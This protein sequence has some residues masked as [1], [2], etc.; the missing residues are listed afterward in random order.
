ML[1]SKFDLY[2]TEWLELVFANRNKEYGAY[3]MRAHYASTLTRAMAITF[4]AVAAMAT[5]VTI[6]SN[7]KTI[8]NGDRM[9]PVELPTLPT[10]PDKVVEIKKE[11]PPA[12]KI[13]TQPA[14][15]PAISTQN[16]NYKVV[17]D[18]KVKIDPKPVDPN[19][20]SGPVDIIV[21]GSDPTIQ[22]QGEGTETGKGVDPKSPGIDEGIHNTGELLDVMPEPVGGADAWGRFLQKNLRFPVAARE[23]GISGKVFL[24][25]IIEKDGHLTDITV[26][27]KAGSGFDEESLR[28]LKLAPAWKPGMQNGQKVRVRYTIP[29]NFQL[30]DE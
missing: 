9:V 14:K 28:V 10:N 30:A 29:I 22:N 6:I 27:R 18:D 24:S 2:K 23:N 1:I 19:I 3:Q 13:E 17:T 16:I 25:F 11:Q 26:I 8:D 15:A 7:N 20:A 5:T 21:P 12:K 4:F